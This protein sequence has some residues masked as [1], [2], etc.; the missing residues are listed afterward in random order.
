M[1]CVN[2][3]FHFLSRFLKGYSNIAEVILRRRKFFK[4]PGNRIIATTW[5][6]IFSRVELR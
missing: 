6:K 3:D 4:M 5:T 1:K 2:N